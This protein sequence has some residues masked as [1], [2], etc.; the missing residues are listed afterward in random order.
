MTDL[1]SVGEELTGSEV[2]GAPPI[3]WEM[4]WVEWGGVSVEWR[5]GRVREVW[6]S[7]VVGEK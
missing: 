6:G 7:S 5:S 3:R 2:S 4:E 1:A